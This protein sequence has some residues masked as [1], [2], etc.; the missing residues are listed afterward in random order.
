[1]PKTAVQ[2]HRQ[3]R[4]YEGHIDRTSC[5]SWNAVMDTKAK[6]FTKQS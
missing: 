6:A 3:T 2:E 4:S 5:D 1:M